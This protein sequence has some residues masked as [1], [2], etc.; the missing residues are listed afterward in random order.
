[1][2]VECETLLIILVSLKLIP[3]WILLMASIRL[4]N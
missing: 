3:C 2:R 4:V 1:M